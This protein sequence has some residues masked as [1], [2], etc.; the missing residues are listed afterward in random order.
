MEVVGLDV[1]PVAVELAGELAARHGVANR[2]RFEQIDLDDGLPEGSPVDVIMMH[3]FWDPRL[4]G[5]LV[6]RLAHG[7]LLA[8]A[9][10]SEVDS[11][12][13]RFRLP[14][15]A[16]ADVFEGVAELDTVASGESGG[17]AWH[18]ATRRAD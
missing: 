12:P 1:S 3:L 14:R 15:N 2:C 10:L 7:G 13:G 18:L 11:E 17:R 16:L 9:T 5:P 4:A 8:V 6:D